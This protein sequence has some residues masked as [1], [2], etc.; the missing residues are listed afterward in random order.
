MPCSF[1]KCWTGEG[2]LKKLLMPDA[3]RK[4]LYKGIK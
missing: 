4:L 3:G 1:K 2:I